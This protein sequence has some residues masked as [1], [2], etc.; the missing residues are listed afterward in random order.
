MGGAPLTG[1]R[2]CR[3]RARA[4]V[5]YPVALLRPAS[6]WLSYTPAS[7]TRTS[8]PT[9]GGTALPLP[10]TLAPHRPCPMAPPGL[11]GGMRDPVTRCRLSASHLSAVLAYALYYRLNYISQGGSGNCARANL[12]RKTKEVEHTLAKLEKEGVEIDDKIVSIID[13]EVVRIKDE[14]ARDSIV[15]EPRGIGT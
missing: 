11:L 10:R 3:A 1:R 15:N 6:R 4:R 9:P 8:L 2:A 12:A 13:D 5:G 14:A 7:R